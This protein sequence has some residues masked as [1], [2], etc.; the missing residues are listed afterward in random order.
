MISTTKARCFSH[1]CQSFRLA[2]VLLEWYSLLLHADHAVFKINVKQALQLLQGIHS[3]SPKQGFL[4]GNATGHNVKNKR[5]RLVPGNRVC[6]LGQ[7]HITASGS[8]EKLSSQSPKGMKFTKR[9]V[10]AF[11]LS[12]PARPRASTDPATSGRSQLSRPPAPSPLFTAR[13][14]AM[15][16]V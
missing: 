4:F 14:S 8:G 10:P 13:A 5:L 2:H 15:Q 3:A 1:R 12:D 6:C 7:G 16:P 11:A 9:A